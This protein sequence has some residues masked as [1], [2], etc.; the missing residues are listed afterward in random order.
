MPAPCSALLK[1]L[2]SGRGGSLGFV[3]FSGGLGGK[4][5]GGTRQAGAGVGGVSV[6]AGKV[7]SIKRRKSLKSVLS[8]CSQTDT[9]T[10]THTLLDTSVRQARE[11]LRLSR[12]SRWIPGLMPAAQAGQPAAQPP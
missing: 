3:A 5:L 2:D 11:S 7:K 12:R 6:S 8:Y 9:H 4:S 1:T 10:Q